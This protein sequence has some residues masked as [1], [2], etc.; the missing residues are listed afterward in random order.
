MGMFN[1]PGEQPAL[2]TGDEGRCYD[3]RHPVLVLR[4]DEH[5]FPV[6]G[7]KNALKSEERSF[8]VDGC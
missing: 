3:D 2:D 4:I 8:T 7:N 5:G 6:I 1:H